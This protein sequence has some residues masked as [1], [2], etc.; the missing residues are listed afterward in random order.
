[1][2]NSSLPAY[3]ES[4]S[5]NITIANDTQVFKNYFDLPMTIGFG[6]LLIISMLFAFFG[7]LLVILVILKNR[8]MRDDSSKTNLFLCNLAV[9][10]LFVGIL[11]I[12]FSFTVLI[13]GTWI[14]PAW[15]CTFN[16]FLNTTCFLTS[17][18]T[19]MY[20]A[21]HKYI[22]LSRMN[23]HFTNIK[24]FIM[25]AAAWTWGLVFAIVTT[26]G[27]G[28]AV[29]KPKTMQ[30]GPP[31]PEAELKTYI[32]HALNMTINLLIPFGIMTFAYIK[33]YKMIKKSETFRRKNSIRDSDQIQARDNGVSCTLFIVLI[34]FLLCW[35]PYLFY[36]NFA[37]VIQ[38]K[39]DI[40]VYL[41][42]L[43]YCF[44]YMNSACNPIIYAWRFPDF[45]KGYK[46]LLCWYKNTYEVTRDGRRSHL[47]P[48][49]R[50][51]EAKF[52]LRNSNCGTA[53]T[54]KTFVTPSKN[55]QDIK[56]VVIKSDE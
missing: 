30:C 15:F 22:C 50:T 40:P 26:S 42:P 34:C 28:K 36:I 49:Y 35:L 19:L 53:N 4:T 2:E 39:Q 18:H 41:N 47:S 3:T 21:I 7:N 11:M 12:P 51:S 17:I 48:L 23:Y 37:T 25:I 46:E 13:K 6:S 55:S 44:G 16:S 31:Y 20:I 38:N 5:L 9:A 27:L 45:R 29:Y 14:F 33:I 8:R 54:K 24:C 1:M 32:L 52:M 10:D 43:A 56:D